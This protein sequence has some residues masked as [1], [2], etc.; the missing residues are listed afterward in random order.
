MNFVLVQW[1]YA[2]GSSSISLFT[3]E[4]ISAGEIGGTAN[5][6]LECPDHLVEIN[7]KRFSDGDDASLTDLWNAL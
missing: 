4:E 6:L 7:L 1:V 5:S 2:D 3:P